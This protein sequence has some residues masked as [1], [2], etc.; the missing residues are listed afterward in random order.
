MCSRTRKV[1][2]F[3]FITTTEK[4]KI[5]DFKLFKVKFKNKHCKNSSVKNYGK[6]NTIK[7]KESYLSGLQIHFYGNNNKVIIEKGSTFSN[8]TFN[9]GLFNHP[10]NNCEI[11]IGK[12]CYLNWGNIDILTDNCVVKIKENTSIQNLYAR[13]PHK[14]SSITIEKNSMLSWGVQIIPHDGHDIIN[15]NDE[16]TINDCEYQIKIGEHCWIG[17]D[18][19]LIHSATIPKNSIVGAN[20]LVNKEFNIENAIYA[21]VPAKLIRNNITWKE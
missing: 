12:N 11:F 19:K 16:K 17:S 21:G 1:K 8:F 9:F 15:L 3:M 14:K 20:S 2:Y 4:H 5:L 18:V 7:N 10:V 13:L 6:N